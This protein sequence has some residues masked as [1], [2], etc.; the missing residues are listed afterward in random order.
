MLAIMGTSSCH[1]LLGNEEILVPGICGCVED[2]ILP[3]YFGYEAG[4]SCMG[5]HFAWFTENCVSAE[6]LQKAKDA[7]K[8]I[9]AYLQEKMVDE[10]PGESG[11]VALD[12]WNGNRSVLVDVDLTGLMIGMIGTITGHELIHRT[13]DASSM[14]IGRWLLAFS[15]DASFAV[16]HVYG[17]H[18]YVATTA[19]P[20]TAPRG[21]NV[22]F[23]VLVSTIRG[24]VS[25]WHIEA[26]RLR[27]RRLPLGSWQNAVVRGYAMSLALLGAAFA[28]GAHFGFD[29]GVRSFPYVAIWSQDKKVLEENLA[30]IR[31]VTGKM[32]E[33]LEQLSLKAGGTV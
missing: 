17:H 25:A 23:H 31:K 14:L 32:I 29:S 20:A 21:R 11:L 8:D 10:K 18:R 30:A 5:D 28:I 7:G 4:Q 1:M 26:E 9:H 22:Y 13:W 33:G 3:G 19:D 6:Y 15:F 2:G 12:W 27:K 16:E 24:N